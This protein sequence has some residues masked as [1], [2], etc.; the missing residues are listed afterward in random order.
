MGKK[1]N[2]VDAIRSQ[3]RKGYMSMGVLGDGFGADEGGGGG[4]ELTD[5]GYMM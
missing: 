5:G 2:I 4:Q 3:G 1:F